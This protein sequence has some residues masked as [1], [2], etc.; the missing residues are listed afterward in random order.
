MSRLTWPDKSP[1]HG[2]AYD[3]VPTKRGSVYGGSLDAHDHV[4]Y[5]SIL[6]SV[7]EMASDIEAANNAPASAAIDQ[8]LKDERWRILPRHR[9]LIVERLAA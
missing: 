6:D 1:R 9:K 2:F 7:F 8:V 5:G 4:E 3:R